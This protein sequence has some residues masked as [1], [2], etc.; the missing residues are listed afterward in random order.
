MIVAPYAGKR[1]SPLNLLR[2][3]AQPILKTMDC[4]DIDTDVSFCLDPAT[5]RLRVS[6]EFRDYL[7][8]PF[9]ELEGAAF[10]E[11]LSSSDGVKFFRTVEAIRRGLVCG[12]SILR[13]TLRDS[14]RR[15]FLKVSGNE[16]EVRGEVFAEPIGSGLID[17]DS[18]VSMSRLLE[19]GEGLRGLLQIVADG[20]QAELCADR[21]VLITF[22]D[23]AI[24]HFIKAGPGADRVVEVEYAELW[25]GLSGWVMRERST[26]FSPRET[27]DDRESLEVRNR[28]R[29]TECGDIIVA[30]LIH[31]GILLGTL[32]AINTPQ[33]APFTGEDTDMLEALARMS[34]ASVFV[35]R[36]LFGRKNQIEELYRLATHD[37]LTR[38]YNRRMFADIANRAVANAR[39]QSRGLALAFLDLDGF[40]QVNDSY[41]HYYGDCLLKESA[42][43]IRADIRET[44]TAARMG[45]DEFV[46]LFENADREGVE[47]AVGRLIRRLGEPYAI[48]G[49]ADIR[50]GASA[51]VAFFPSDAKTYGEL[52]R[53]ADQA[54]YRAKREGKNTYRVH[55]PASP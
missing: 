50:V 29:E 18:L 14:G 39:R 21:V 12:P 34:A 22:E 32:T 3:P 36:S 42:S 28:R 31:L 5:L 54:L 7:G 37:E 1:K 9:S 26:A 13:L 16:R 30:P 45:G 25:S 6:P 44:E 38:L 8:V 20:V 23:E 17:F 41:G 55:E 51:G 49:H 15:L 11:L 35:A 47:A 24:D 4:R 19:S 40:K 43:R 33:N 2:R 46:V 52:L 27:D 53:L 10:R 48:A